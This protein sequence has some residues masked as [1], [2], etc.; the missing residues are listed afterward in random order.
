MKK[1]LVGLLLG[2]MVLGSSL[3][4]SADSKVGQHIVVNTPSKGSISCGGVDGK[5][6]VKCGNTTVTANEGDTITV[7]P[8]S[9]SFSVGCY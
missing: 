8:G 1:Y 7:N 9:H 3:S 6:I 4:V 5:I 2:T